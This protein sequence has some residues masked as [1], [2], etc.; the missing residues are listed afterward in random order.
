VA[1]IAATKIR[2][3]FEEALV[4]CLHLAAQTA[5]PGTTGKGIEHGI[6]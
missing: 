3:S 6:D 5:S 4:C 2:M 1:L